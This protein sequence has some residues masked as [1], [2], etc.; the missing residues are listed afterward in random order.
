M[1]PRPSCVVFL[2]CPNMFS[3]KD[4]LYL[5]AIIST[6]RL[7]CLSPKCIYCL[8]MNYMIDALPPSLN[9]IFI[10]CEIR[11]DKLDRSV[12]NFEFGY[13]NIVSVCSWS[14]PRK[15]CCFRYTHDTSCPPRFFF[16]NELYD[17]CPPPLSF[18]RLVNTSEVRGRHSLIQPTFCQH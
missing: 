8:P 18:Y 11:Y 15:S 1:N 17:R 7:V 6:L 10:I 16:P 9:F 14:F 5:S 4:A 2:F 12:V 13:L 3:S